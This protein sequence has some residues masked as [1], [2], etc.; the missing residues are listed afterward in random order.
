MQEKAVA[1]RQLEPGGAYVPAEPADA[2][3]DEV[4]TSHLAREGRLA[5]EWRTRRH[6]DLRDP[7]L[8]VDDPGRPDRD[9][10]HRDGEAQLRHQTAHRVAHAADDDHVVVAD[11]GRP[12]H[13][14]STGALD[15]DEG[16]A[17]VCREVEPSCRHPDHGRAGTHAKTV[18]TV[19]E[20]VVR[21]EAVGVVTE[22]PHGLRRGPVGEH[23]RCEQHP[24]GDGG[25]DERQADH[26]EVEEP[27]RRRPRL[28]G[29]LGHD[30]VDG[31]ARQ[32]EQ[33]AGAAG[34]GH[35]HEHQ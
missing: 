8:T 6:D 34:E 16:H 22:V 15:A 26:R 3:H 11:R 19:V 1:R 14:L 10:P 24:E 2:E 29:R 27:E 4:S 33:G 32:G 5:H 7:D 20:L 35:R 13:G 28:D 31:A 25:H 30:D 21:G 17:G 9:G 18:E 12:R 23:P